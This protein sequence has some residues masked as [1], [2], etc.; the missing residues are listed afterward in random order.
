MISQRQLLS[1]AT[2]LQQY[3]QY[4]NIVISTHHDDIRVITIAEAARNTARQRYQLVTTILRTA[5][6]NE[7]S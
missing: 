3:I 4:C 7:R 5:V 1:E 2:E 6:A